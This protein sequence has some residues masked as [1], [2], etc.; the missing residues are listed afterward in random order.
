SW[1]ARSRSTRPASAV[2]IVSSSLRP[3]SGA[4]S[5]G[6][7]P[8]SSS[9]STAIHALTTSLFPLAATAGAPPYDI[10]RRVGAQ[11]RAPPRPCPAAAPVPGLGRLR[12]PGSHVDGV[13][14]DHQL[15]P[16]CGFAAGHD[17]AGVHA[18]PQSHISAE[19]VAY[20]SGE[21]GKALV[22]GEPGPD[23]ALG[24]VFV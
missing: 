21:T 7:M 10:E 4:W 6:R 2:R 15:A 11:V 20:A 17:L 18:D 8:G 14:A 3:T 12:E 5:A 23:R 13:A 24:V 19:A 22:C 9:G 1:G 16:R